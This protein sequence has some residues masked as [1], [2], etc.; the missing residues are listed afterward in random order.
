MLELILIRI[1]AGFKSLQSIMLEDDSR[2]L[3][4]HS[5]QTY[6]LIGHDFD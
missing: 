5:I 2:I 1:P 3:A 4:L 6:I